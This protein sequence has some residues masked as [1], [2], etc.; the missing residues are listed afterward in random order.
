MADDSGRLE[1]SVGAGHGQ[2]KVDDFNLCALCVYGLQ[3]NSSRVLAVRILSDTE[4]DKNDLTVNLALDGNTAGS[5]TAGRAV[6]G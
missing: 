5:A 6:R 1:P 3:V 2:T 4:L